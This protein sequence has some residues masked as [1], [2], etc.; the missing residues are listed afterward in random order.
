VSTSSKSGLE[1]TNEL[2]WKV[3]FRQ[4]KPERYWQLIAIIACSGPV[5]YFLTGQFLLALIVPVCLVVSTWDVWRGKHFLLNE[6]KAVAGFSEIQWKDI[7]RIERS[8]SEIY[9]SPF[10]RPNR[11]ESTRGV[12][13]TVPDHLRESAD[14]FLLLKLENSKFETSIESEDP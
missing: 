13:L 14:K 11:L 4:E 8:G 6:T 5:G 7:K 12:R 10:E 1:S 2:R 9:L 3:E